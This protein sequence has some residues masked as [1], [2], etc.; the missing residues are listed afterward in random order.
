M[1]F[2]D[3][4]TAIEMLRRNPNA[5]HGIAAFRSEMIG[6][7]SADVDLM[8]KHVG[9]LWL[10]GNLWMTIPIMG[11]SVFHCELET[12]HR[13]IIAQEIAHRSRLL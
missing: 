2:E 1:D 13:K 8:D 6:R 10:R 9:Q 11:I 12:Q 3:E 4:P 7:L 5:S